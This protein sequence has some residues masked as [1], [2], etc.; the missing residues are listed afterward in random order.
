MQCEDEPRRA[1]QVGAPDAAGQRERLGLDVLRKP[2]SI[3]LYPV[4][5]FSIVAAYRSAV[6]LDR[7]DL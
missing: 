5:A 1:H 7:T 6:L 3:S 4:V 2:F